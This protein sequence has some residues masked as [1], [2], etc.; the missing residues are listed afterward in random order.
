MSTWSLHRKDAYF[1]KYDA[2][3]GCSTHFVQLG[4]IIVLEENQVV[5]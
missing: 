5:I 1:L 3:T 2:Y 4:Y